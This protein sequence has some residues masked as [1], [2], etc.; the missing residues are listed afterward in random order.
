MAQ[1]WEVLFVLWAII[2]LAGV[3]VVQFAP[4]KKAG[5]SNEGLAAGCTLVAVGLLLLL[6]AAV[7][8]AITYVRVTVL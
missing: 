8:W 5:E 2:T 7:V 1:I 6:A 3:V 4:H